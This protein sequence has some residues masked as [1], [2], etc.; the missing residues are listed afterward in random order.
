MHAQPGTNTYRVHTP[1]V[2]QE[3]EGNGHVRFVAVPR[4]SLMRVSG[5]VE[6]FGFVDVQWNGKKLSVFSRDI[7][8]RAE[9]VENPDEVAQTPGR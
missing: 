5:R 3:E 1:L 9:R 7:Q 6:S 2:A 4:G 8:E